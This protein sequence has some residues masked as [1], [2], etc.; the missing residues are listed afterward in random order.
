MV[1]LKDLSYL[2]CR[3]F[4]VYG[5]QIGDQNSDITYNSICKQI[6]EGVREGFTETEI[7]RGVLRIVKP[8]AFKDM[9]TNKDERTICELKG[10]LRSHL[11]E[12]AGT[13]LFH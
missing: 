5:G 4:K 2:Q 1:S 6:D 13:E 11:G 10:F 7:I 8:G 9:L 3:E 12:R